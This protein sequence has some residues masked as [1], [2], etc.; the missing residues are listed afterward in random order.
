[1]SQRQLNIKHC[2][3]Y[4]IVESPRF[5]IFEETYNEDFGTNYNSQLR[6]LLDLDRRWKSL[7]AELKEKYRRKWEQFQKFKERNRIICLE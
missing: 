6:C 4:M 5:F 7:G 2:H 1:M 3:E